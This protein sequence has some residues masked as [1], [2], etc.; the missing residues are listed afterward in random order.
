MRLLLSIAAVLIK[1]LRSAGSIRIKSFII[2]GQAT[3]TEEFCDCQASHLWIFSLDADERSPM[4]CATLSVLNLSVR[5][6]TDTVFPGRIIFLGRWIKYGGC[7]LTG[8]QAVPAR[9]RSVWR[10]ES[11]R[12]GNNRERFGGNAG[13]PDSALHLS[14]SGS[15]CGEGEFLHKYHGTRAF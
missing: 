13:C 10:K 6:M 2:R 3:R 5:R 7:F 14:I 15:L 11:P 12:Q 4:S 8:S 9:S 1:R